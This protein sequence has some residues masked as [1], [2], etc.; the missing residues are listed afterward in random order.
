[1]VRT[2]QTAM[3]AAIAPMSPRPRLPVAVEAGRSEREYVLA[4]QRGD[5][6]A[7]SALVRLHLR[8]AYAVAR[9]LVLTHEDAEGGGQG[10][11]LH[12]SRALDRFPPAQPF[13]AW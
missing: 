1:M 4:A 6:D 13:G 10:G 2:V 12:A 3:T 7:F 9:A 11:F 8:R 5:Q